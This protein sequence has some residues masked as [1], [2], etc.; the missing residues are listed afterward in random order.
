MGEEYSNYN[1][2]YLSVQEGL[3]SKALDVAST[4]VPVFEAAALLIAEIDALC[5]MAHAAVY[6]PIPYVCPTLCPAGTSDTLIT[7]SRHPV[8]EFQDDVSFIANDI[9]LKRDDGRFI[10]ITGPNMGGKR[11]V[12][13]L[14]SHCRLCFT[15]FISVRIF[16]KLDVFK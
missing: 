9:V 4:Y 11:L 8:V 7:Q 5:S 3:V 14:F 1:E 15:L 13:D 6:A 12:V 16:D 2:E 10:I